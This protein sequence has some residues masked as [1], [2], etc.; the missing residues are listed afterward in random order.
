MRPF[1]VLRIICALVCL[2]TPNALAQYTLK[3]IVFDGPSPYTQAALE[4][5]SGLKPG[6]HATNDT[7][8]QAAQRLSDTGAFGDLQVTFDGPATAISI[9]F[10][11]K[12][13]DPSHQLTATFDNMIWFTPEEL[14]KGLRARVPLYASILPESG[15]LQDTVQTALADMLKEKGITATLAH[16]IF[17]PSPLRP[18]R[19]VAY[20]VTKPA[21]R[22]H[23]V[24]L[25][26]ISPE[27]AAP[28]REIQTRIVGKPFNEGL[29]ELTTAEVLLAPYL[30][31]GYLNAHLTS[32]TLTPT[33]SSQ[34]RVDVDLAAVVDAGVPFHIGTVAWAG[35]PQMSSEA[36]ATASPLHTGDLATPAALA[37]SIDL[38]A[39]PYRKQGYADVIVSPN[40]SIDTSTNRVSYAFSVIPGEIYRIRTLTPLNLTP[41]QQ[42][43]FNRG[44]TLKAGDVFNSEY[45][46]NFL[47]QNSALRSFDG[48]S[49]TFKAIRDP[50]SR[51]VDV[52][53][54]FLHGTTV[55]VH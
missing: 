22:L 18:I 43:D 54:T 4:A 32:R 2:A 26:G 9:I 15:N 48:Y 41:A 8:Q 13:L 49:A 11:I 23:S 17:E 55:V 51:L 44:W 37:K 53:V 10:K 36:F 50:E 28:I 40:P 3:K 21:I 6:D 1:G 45:I 12:P 39:A 16:E 31:A 30:K 46:T 42:A 20:R 7:L 38:L 25:T 33:A 5:A 35:S 27:F 47:Q 24:N 19:I 29:E 34:D 52:T 14:E